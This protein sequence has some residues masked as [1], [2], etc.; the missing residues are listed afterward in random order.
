[1]RFLLIGAI[2]LLAGCAVTAPEPT[3]TPGPPRSAWGTIFTLASAEQMNAPAFWPGSTLPFAWVEADDAAVTNRLARLS[4]AGIAASG[5]VPLPVRP[6]AQTLLPAAEG[7]LH[8]FWL[9]ANVE[10]ETR[11]FHA[12]ITPNLI[13]ERGPTIVSDE[14]TLAYALLPNADGSVWAV[15]TGGLLSEPGLFARFVDGQGRPRLENLYQIAYDAVWPAFL[16]APDGRA[17]FWLGNRD[18]QVYRAAFIDGQP[19]SPQAITEAPPLGSGD[20][21][22]D[23]LAG[24]DRSHEML[25]W[26]I[27]RADGTAETWISAAPRGGSWTRPTRLGISLSPDQPF[28]T[29]FNGGAGMPAA[30]G[31]SRLSWLRPLNGLFN[32]LPAAAL[33]DGMLGV[34]YFQAGEIVGWQPVVPLSGLLAAPGFATDRDRHLYLS[35]SEPVAGEPARLQ[36]TSTRP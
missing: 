33:L 20:R 2:L 19:E 7:K 24:Q 18:G 30:P 6:Y 29:G 34:V 9:D 36:F 8:L 5:S 32:T 28:E 35:W 17:L 13:V 11:L 4:G 23:F 27:R 22:D 1:M 21:L 16:D 15:T 10:D 26:N 31:E 3:A 12:L 14:P 25:F